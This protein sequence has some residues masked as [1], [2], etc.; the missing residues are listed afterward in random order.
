MPSAGTAGVALAVPLWSS[1]APA[2]PRAGE[3]RTELPADRLLINPTDAALVA[4]AWAAADALLLSAIDDPATTPPIRVFAQYKLESALVGMGR[5]D[6]ARAP[7]EAV[8]TRPIGD[9]PQARW[10]REQALGDLAEV[11]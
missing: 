1:S 8:A 9:A 5:E 6:E 4:G 2:A 10:L 7:L 3:R 11:P